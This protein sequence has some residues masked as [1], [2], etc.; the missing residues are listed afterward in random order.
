MDNMLPVAF[1]DHDDYVWDI[2]FNPD[3]D[4]LLT[5]ARGGVLKRWPTRPEL[6]VKDI[7][8]YL[9]RNMTRTEWNRFVAEDIEYVDTCEKVGNT[10]QNK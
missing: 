3:G 2:E 8:K 4:Y 6:M 1:K 7:C 10:S 5:G 9:S